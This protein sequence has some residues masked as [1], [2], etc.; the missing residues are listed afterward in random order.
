[1]RLM[2]VAPH[3]DDE[4]LG[5]GGTIARYSA[6]GNDVIVVVVTKGESTL[7]DPD[8]I[9][10]GRREALKA[11]SQL[12][13]EET[14]FMDFPAARLDSVEHHSLNSAFAQIMSK[15]RPEVVFLP[16]PGDIHKDH[17]LTFESALVALRPVTAECVRE[18][19]CY[20]TVSETNWSAPFASPVFSP[21][22][23]IDISNYLERKVAALK[24][25]ASQMKCFP[26]ERSIE[27]VTSLATARGATVG[28]C[29]AEAF[30]QVRRII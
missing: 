16:F 5:A 20:E 4:V 19:L 8:I 11:H 15:V 10:T 1:M 3:P 17:R 12:G 25:F 14:I 9:D 2:V 26:N 6:E 27:A 23:Y 24:T 7:F 13:V 21:D 30:V 29:A 22:V 28:R 18:I